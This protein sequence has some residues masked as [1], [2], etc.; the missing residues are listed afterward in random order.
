MTILYNS[1]ELIQK[2][3]VEWHIPYVELAIFDTDSASAIADAINI[4]CKEYLGSAVKGY[5]FYAVSVGSTHGIMLEDERA[6]VI[7]A[8]PPSRENP[9]LNLD[10][11]KLETVCRVMQWLNDHD[12]PCP[13]P[14][15]GPTPLGKGLATVEEYLSHGEHGDGFRSDCRKT[16][17]STFSELIELL[18]GYNIDV[19]NLQPPVKDES[20]YP[21]PHGKIFNFETTSGGAGWIDEFA[22][23][24]RKGIS[25]KEGKVLGHGDWRV[26]HL[27]FQD[28]KIVA[29]YDWDSLNFCSET[30]LVGRTAH[31]FTADWSVP[32]ARHVP[33]GKDIRAFIADYEDVRERLF[34]KMERRAVFASCVYWIAYNARCQHSL[35][36]QKLEW[37]ED[38]FPHLLKNEGEMLLT[39]YDR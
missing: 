31:G 32:G 4:F 8:R 13:K 20:L 34:S 24:A 6:V 3:L 1:V 12:F 36:P 2:T 14:V 7:K 19:R 23:R 18:R 9:S 15:L 21:Q 11:D 38:S 29:T 5:L 16:I 39:N 25:W 35:E 28:G 33:T 10:R 37:E 17:A 30:E 22:R 27:R 26:E